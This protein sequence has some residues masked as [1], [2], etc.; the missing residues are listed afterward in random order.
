S[1]YSN[2][3]QISGTVARIDARG[4]QGDQQM[5]HRQGPVGESE[6]DGTRSVDKK[7]KVRQCQVAFATGCDIESDTGSEA[8]LDES[9]QKATASLWMCTRL[10]GP[11]WGLKPLVAFWAY[12]TVVRPIITYAAVV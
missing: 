1:V 4:P 11:N 2:N 7:A 5:V 9:C 3:G 12:A 10:G 8:Y 6:K